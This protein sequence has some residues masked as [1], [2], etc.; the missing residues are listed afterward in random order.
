MNNESKYWLKHIK[1]NYSHIQVVLMFSFHDGQLP[2][3][4]PADQY[5][6]RDVVFALFLFRHEMSPI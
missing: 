3:L 1:A 5:S 2:S 6:F 4:V